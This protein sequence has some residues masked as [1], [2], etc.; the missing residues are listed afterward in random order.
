MAKD[1]RTEKY[2][3]LAEQ[4][5]DLYLPDEAHPPV[6]CLLHGGFWRMPHGMEQMEAIA[7]DLASRGFAVWNLEYSRIGAATGGWPGTFDDVIAGIEHLARI[8]SD[9]VDLDLERVIVSGHSAGGHLALWSAAH[10]L[11][12][13]V[14]ISAVVGQAP[15]ADL[16]RA[17]ELGVGDGAVSE[18][19]GGPPAECSERYQAASP[20]ALTPIGVP[21]LLIHGT[22]DKVVPIEISRR[23]ASVAQSAGDKVD[24]LELQDLGHMNFL[25]PTSRAH[26]ALCDWLARICG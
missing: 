10:Q 1:V 11:E 8:V 23:Y 21:Q 17:Y 19:L 14:R 13:K 5:G 18:L 20:I 6:V 3:V 16:V 9:G 25:D 7:C 26:A 4:A 22:A 12:R 15:L 2:G 24:L